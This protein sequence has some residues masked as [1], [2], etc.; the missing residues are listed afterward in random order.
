MPLPNSGRRAAGDTPGVMEA[1]N[2]LQMYAPVG[3]EEFDP[4]QT[5][6]GPP[7]Q[8]GRG[9]HPSPGGMTEAEKAERARQ[10]QQEMKQLAIQQRD[11]MLQ[12]PVQYGSKALNF[13]VDTRDDGVERIGGD[14]TI[15]LDENQKFRVGG[16]VLPGYRGEEGI[17]VPTGLRIEGSYQT[18]G[19]TATVTHRSGRRGGGFSAQADFM[20]RW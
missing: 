18:P 7:L 13:A 15:T 12:Q 11:R 9:F 2:R 16:S 10:R 14:A 1:M 5:Q 17:D 6:F 20:T 8:G 19:M 4:R 3:D